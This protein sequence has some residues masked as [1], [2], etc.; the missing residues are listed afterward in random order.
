MTIRLI[1]AFVLLA[2]LV[3]A[4]ARGRVLRRRA[5]DERRAAEERMRAAARDLDGKVTHSDDGGP[6]Y[7]DAI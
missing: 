5:E 2:A 6:Q 3:T 7:R 1:I 4:N